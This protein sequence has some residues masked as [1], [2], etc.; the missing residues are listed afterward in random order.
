MLTAEQKNI[1]IKYLFFYQPESIGLFGSYA[2]NEE[3]PESDI[4]II[5]SLKEKPSLLQLIKME[6]ELSELLN[7]KVEL[8]TENSIKHPLLKAHIQRDKKILYSC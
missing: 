3:K 4:D 5:I 7:K 8:I 6:R 1:I 2:R